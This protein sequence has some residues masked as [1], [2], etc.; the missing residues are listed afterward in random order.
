[1][2]EMFCFQCQ[3]TAGNKGC[4][5]VGVC[6]KQPET[7]KLTNKIIRPFDNGWIIYHIDKYKF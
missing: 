5:H 6:G 3:Q 7:L 4:T 1:M 2:S